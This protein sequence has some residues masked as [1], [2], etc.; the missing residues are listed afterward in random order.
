MKFTGDCI[1][2][3][4]AKNTAIFGKMLN[5]KSKNAKTI[6]NKEYSIFNFAFRILRSTYT[7]TKNE[8]TNKI[9][10]NETDILSPLSKRLYNYDRHQHSKHI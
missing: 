9:I 1:P 6:Q 4:P 7:A 10:L 8:T 5:T 3:S 2:H